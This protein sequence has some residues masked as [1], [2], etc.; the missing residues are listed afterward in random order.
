MRLRFLTVLGLGD[1]L[2]NT[3][4]LGNI[5]EKKR[6]T[7]VKKSK[8]N[9]EK[10]TERQQGKGNLRSWRSHGNSCGT[11]AAAAAGVCPSGQPRHEGS[12]IQTATENQPKGIRKK[13]D[14]GKPNQKDQGSKTQERKPRGSRLKV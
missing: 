13:Q 10:D 4:E 11:V 2:S 1:P 14:R 5:I 8:E 3:R 9:Q 12:P 7:R 6:E